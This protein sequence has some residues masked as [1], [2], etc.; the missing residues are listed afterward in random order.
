MKFRPFGAQLSHA[1]GQ[2]EDRQTWWS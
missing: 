2:T 1:G